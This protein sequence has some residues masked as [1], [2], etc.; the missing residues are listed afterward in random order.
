MSSFMRRAVVAVVA[1]AAGMALTTATAGPSAA[2]GYD[3]AEG[4][5]ERGYCVTDYGACQQALDAAD[6]ASAVT[7]WLFPGYGGHNDMA[8]AFRHCAWSGAT[9]Q[10]LGYQQAVE[11]TGNH[12]LAAGQPY[13]EYMMDLSNNAVGLVLAGQSAYYG[14]ADTWGWIMNQCQ[15]LATSYQLYGPGGGFGNY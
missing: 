11:L 14:G 4:W 3:S 2:A 15:Y 5:Y 8:D 12:E 6:W 1:A 13:D 9:G 10:R 7:A